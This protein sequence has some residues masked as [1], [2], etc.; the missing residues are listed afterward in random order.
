[1]FIDSEKLAWRLCPGLVRLPQEDG[2][3]SVAGFR[4]KWGVFNKHTQS[5]GKSNRKK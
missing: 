1:M 4:V 3:S 5:K 2:F